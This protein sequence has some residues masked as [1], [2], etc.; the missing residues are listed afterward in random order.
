MQQLT[1]AQLCQQLASKFK[2]TELHTAC[3]LGNV[4]KVMALLFDGEDPDVE[5]D[6][7][8]TPLHIASYEG[9]EEVVRVLLS[10]N[11][12]K[13]ATDTDGWSPLHLASHRGHTAIVE[14]L[15][16]HGEVST[17]G[18][19]TSAD[20][21]FEC[22]YEH[23]RLVL[24]RRSCEV[25]KTTKDPL[26]ISLCRH[27]C[28]VKY[29]HLIENIQRHN[30][31]VNKETSSCKQTALYLASQEGHA[32][33]MQVLLEHGACSDATDKDLEHY[34]GE[35]RAAAETTKQRKTSPWISQPEQKQFVERR[36]DKRKIQPNKPCH[37]EQ[38]CCQYQWTALHVASSVGHV[39]VVRLLLKYSASARRDKDN[40]LPLHVA[41]TAQLAECEK[42]SFQQPA[43][44]RPSDIIRTLLKSNPKDVQKAGKDGKSPLFM[45][46]HHGSASMVR[47]LLENGAGVEPGLIMIACK[48]GD[49]D[50]LNVLLE[51]NA[52][53]DERN[54]DSL[55]PGEDSPLYFACEKGFEEVVGT[56]INHGHR[57]DYE[58]K[59]GWGTLL[60]IAVT[61]LEKDA[62]TNVREKIV[63]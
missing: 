58:H 48:R 20:I 37:P 17:E 59:D 42:T 41:C 32:V 63:K 47:C 53:I 43:T 49:A 19:V 1:I 10:H 44:D 33:V 39:D 27:C 8:I 26:Q 35:E 22:C 18:E 45:A 14:L 56:L 21:N 25:A 15:L 62:N 16:T 12:D 40:N 3:R 55:F 38:Y 9:Q 5:A 29:R 34:R 54:E 4:E 7:N 50:T 31:C 60:H 24:E 36:T 13:T 61:P 52:D 57:T 6:S 11:A 2:E 23:K 51:N 30:Q 28:D 46:C